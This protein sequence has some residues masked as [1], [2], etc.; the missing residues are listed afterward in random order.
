MIKAPANP[1]DDPSYN[2]NPQNAPVN[3]DPAF[4]APQVP[5]GPDAP[6][7]SAPVQ[8]A[9]ATET[10]KKVE[11]TPSVLNATP[12]SAGGAAPLGEPPAPTV[13]NDGQGGSVPV[14]PA[15]IAP[16][17]V[18]PPAAGATGAPPA[19]ATPDPWNATTFGADSN[20]I[21]TQI[22]PG[23]APDR[24]KMATDQYNTWDAATAPGFEHSMTDATDQAAAH[25]Q[26]RSGQ[27]TNRYGDL[28]RQRVLDQTTARN[29]YM[30]NALDSSI[31]DARSNRNEQRGER[32]YQR[33]L[34]EEAIARRIA[35]QQAESGQGQQDFNNAITQF[36]VGS[37]GDPTGALGDA[38]AQSGQEAQT[39]QADMA[40]LIRAW[41]A[42]NQPQAAA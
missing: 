5:A 3:I 31:T 19:G 36:S 25:G 4:G 22:A 21:N 39:S 40:A 27:L 15:A 33:S 12:A 35:Q 13:L 26:I 1:W 30:Q 38:A 34:A 2:P 18:V 7:R 6:P 32:G 37:Q 9:P 23:A 28:A 10:V 29:S 20:V 16:P 42:R 24:N 41:M 8:A 11:T 17:G 14:P